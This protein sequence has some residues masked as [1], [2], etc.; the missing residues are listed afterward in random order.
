MP[1]PRILKKPAEPPAE[2]D[3]T[4]YQKVPLWG[5]IDEDGV[6]QFPLHPKQWEAFIARERFVAAIAGTGGGKTAMG[7]VWVMRKIQEL[8]QQRDLEVEPILGM[9]VAPTYAILARAT[10]PTFVSSLKD[11]DLEGRYVPTQNRYYLP[12]EMGVIWMLGADNPTGLE[13][14]QFDFIWGDEGGQLKYDAWIALQGRTGQRQ[15]QI[16]F[17]TTPYGENWLYHRFFLMAKRGDVNYKV[18]QWSSNVN[19]AYPEE[20]YHRAKGAMSAQ[21]AAQRYD[22][23]FTRLSGLV[24]PDFGSCILDTHST[25]PDGEKVGGVDFGFNNPFAAL[26]GTV[27]I[28]EKGHDVLYIHYER[29]LREI[30]IPV[31]AEAIPSDHMWWADPASPDAIATL[32]RQGHKVRKA[33]NAIL[34]GV[35]AVNNRIYTGCLRI[36]PECVALIAEADAYRYPEKDDETYGEQPM[37]SN[38]HAL[39]ALRYLCMGLAKRKVA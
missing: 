21:R 4:V 1:P 29:Y 2:T 6:K 11:T 38:D 20:E 17:T 36:S 12:R 31:H 34:P 37:K 7:P 32:R 8:S 5:R 35:D 39:D 10:A 26:G 14:G 24:Y 18:V 3:I 19:P 27:Y 30:T 16:L 22:G 13:G 28:D 9:I 15:A 33:K 25:P 23:L